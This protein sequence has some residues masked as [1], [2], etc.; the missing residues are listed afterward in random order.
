MRSPTRSSSRSRLP[1]RQQAEPLRPDAERRVELAA[2][3]FERDRRG[4]LDDLRLGEMRLKACEEV[5]VDVLAGRGHALGVIERH[6]L[7]FTEPRAV[8]PV[9]RIPY[10]RLA[11]ICFQLTVGIDVDSERAAVDRGD[12]EIDEGQQSLGQLARLLDRGAQQLRRAQ[13]RRAMRHHLG[14]VEE[15]AKRGPLLF[16][17]FVEDPVAA[18]ILDL[19]YPWHRSSDCRISRP[20]S[21]TV[22]CASLF[23]PTTLVHMN[24]GFRYATESE[25]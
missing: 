2:E 20:H 8:A 18:R 3:V 11:V 9:R 14:W 13:D 21:S 16:E 10:F 17:D 23:R 24:R 5:V 12:A 1:L 6:P 4:Q 19:A 25:K 15:V 22:E 7:L